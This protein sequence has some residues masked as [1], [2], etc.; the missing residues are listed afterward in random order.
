MAA[1]T[2]FLLRNIDQAVLDLL[3]EEADAQGRGLSD[4][5]RATLCAHYS[6]DCPPSGSASKLEYGA[7][8]QLLRLQP[9]LYAALSEDADEQGRSVR[10]L[11]LEIL[12]AV[13]V[14]AS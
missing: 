11:I 6:L 7:T 10:S 2:H 13:E 1:W 8:T 14:P 9:E 12:E 4:L 5:I 3:T